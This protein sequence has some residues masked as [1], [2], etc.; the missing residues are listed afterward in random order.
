MRHVLWIALAL[1]GFACRDLPTRDAF[2]WPEDATVASDVAVDV[3]VALDAVDT[4]PNLCGNATCDDGETVATCQQDCAGQF[5]H[6]TGPCNAPGYA[7]GCA[8]GYICVQRTPGAGGDV[9]VANFPTWPPLGVGRKLSDFADGAETVTDTHTGLMWAKKSL[10]NLGFTT[11][12]AACPS[13]V[14]GGFS[15][16]RVPTRAEL[17]SLLDYTTNGP[18]ASAPHLDWVTTNTVYITAVIAP[19]GTPSALGVKWFTGAGVRG[20]LVEPFSVRCVRG[21]SSG[22]PT[23]GRFIASANGTTALDRVSGLL[24]QTGQFGPSR[25]W[26]QASAACLANS[27]QLPGTGW[28]LPNVR[29]LDELREDR[30][31]VDLPDGFQLSTSPFEWTSTLVVAMT[32]SPWMGSFEGESPQAVLGNTPTLHGYRCVR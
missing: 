20:S 29:E 22:T 7:T 26:S 4:G 6:L 16:W 27:A 14:W 5:P 25:N 3:P 31:G 15:D 1:L 24:W 13:Q 10:F 19:E 9:C 23:L 18:A 12:M 21:G 30:D 32:D 2:G 17:R 8:S 28:R 11:A